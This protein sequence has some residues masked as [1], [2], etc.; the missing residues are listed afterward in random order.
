MLVVVTLYVSK[1]K[2]KNSNETQS[3]VYSV[4]PELKSNLATDFDEKNG[5]VSQ[6]VQ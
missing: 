6:E 3:K 1:N 5:Y 2:K 4:G